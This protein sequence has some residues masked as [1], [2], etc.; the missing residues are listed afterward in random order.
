MLDGTGTFAAGGADRTTGRMPP[1]RP[2]RVAFLDI[3]GSLDCKSGGFSLFSREA[4]QGRSSSVSDKQRQTH[5]RVEPRQGYEY[6]HAFYPHSYTQKIFVVLSHQQASR[7]MQTL[8]DWCHTLKRSCLV[9][10]YSYVHVGLGVHSVY[11]QT[12][13]YHLSVRL[14]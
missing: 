1:P 11:Q 4:D 12:I 9:A 14:T 7:S 8:I 10:A 6:I 2:P 13:S 5:Y 3:A